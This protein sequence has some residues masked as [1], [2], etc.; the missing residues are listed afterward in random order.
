MSKK[1]CVAAVQTAVADARGSEHAHDH[2]LTINVVAKM[3]RVSTWTLRFYEWQGL[4]GRDNDGVFNWCD[5]ERI[6][7]IVKAKRAGLT[8]R[9]IA[10]VVKAMNSDA[11]SE[12]LKAGHQCCRDLIAR[13]REYSDPVADVLAE[14]DRIDWEFSA[15]LAASMADR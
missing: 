5:C 15:R 11:S 13:M 1:A 10:P 7:L 6:A 8:V 2:V 12:S 9:Q 4:I 14:L 3:F